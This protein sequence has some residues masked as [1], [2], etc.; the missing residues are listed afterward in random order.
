MIYYNDCDRFACAWMRE[1]MAEGLIPKGDVDER[2]ICDVTPGDVSK[3]DQCHFFGGIG[4]WA[5]AL[6]LAGYK[7]LRCWTGSCPCPSFSSAGKG[8]G[9]A[10]PRGRLWEEFYRLIRQCRPPVCFGEQVENAI[11]FKW[12]DLVSADLEREGYAVGSAVLPAACVGA[13]HVRHRLFWGA[14]LMDDAE[15]EGLEGL[16]EPLGPEQEDGGGEATVHVGPGNAGILGDAQLL[17]RGGRGDGGPPGDDGPLQAE[18]LR[19]ARFWDDIVWFPC[20]DGKRRPISPEPSLFPMADGIPNR[21][22]ILRGAGNAIV[23]QVGARF[24]R[25]FLDSVDDCNRPGRISHVEE[26]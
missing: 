17:G 25:E 13:P 20:Q 22:G 7:N 10:D 3:Y 24:I 16:G 9:F 18:G 14:R 21:M 5:Y 11:R 4:G 26:K 1:L 23:P 15:C 12:L 2:S 19:P 8:E 6:E